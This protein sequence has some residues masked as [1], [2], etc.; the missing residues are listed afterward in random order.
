MKHD[1]ACGCVVYARRAAHARTEGTK[2]QRSMPTK[3]LGERPTTHAPNLQTGSETPIAMT[4]VEC[5]LPQSLMARPPSIP[6]STFCTLALMVMS[7]FR[8]SL[9]VRTQLFL[10]KGHSCSSE[11]QPWV[12]PF[13]AVPYESRP[14]LPRECSCVTACTG[15][16]TGRL[17]TQEISF[18]G[19]QLGTWCL[20]IK[21]WELGDE[22]TRFSSARH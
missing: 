14:S 10:K 3:T 12:P 4:N 21:V 8:S 6:C 5:L 20:Q 16:Q 15:M 2:E 17:F 13:P 7:T 22:L 18:R 9:F 1:R 11:I 19:H